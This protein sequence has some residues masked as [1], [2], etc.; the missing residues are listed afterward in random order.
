MK[1]TCVNP[2]K[3]EYDF[4][5]ARL[6]TYQNGTCR[7]FPKWCPTISVVRSRSEVA[8]ALQAL[9][10]YRRNGWSDK[11]NHFAAGEGWSIFRCDGGSDHGS[12]QLQKDDEIGAFEDD[13]EAWRHVVN[14]ATAGSRVHQRA[15][16][17]LRRESP[18]EYQRIIDASANARPVERK[19]NPCEPMGFIWQIADDLAEAEQWKSELEAKG[20]V[21]LSMEPFEDGPQVHLIVV[22]NKAWAS[23]M[24]GYQPKDEEWLCLSPFA[25]C[26]TFSVEGRQYGELRYRVAALKE[27]D[28]AVLAGLA[29]LE[30]SVY[31]YPHIEFAVSTS[32]TV[33][34]DEDLYQSSCTELQ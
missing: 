3:H 10:E 32:V 31:A 27:D 16:N 12:Y 8:D 9:R 11:D 26:V 18:V 33:L 21:V 15:L 30:Y 20:A 17:F 5:N 34:D 7:E 4:P 25:V 13:G 28:A 23:D 1:A 24:L 19:L 2:I 22:V 6:V 29:A 14:Q